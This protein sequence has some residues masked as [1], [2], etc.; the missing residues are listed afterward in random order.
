MY[1]AH[2]LSLFACSLTHVPDERT[3]QDAWFT[4]SAPTLSLGG[5]VCLRV[6]ASAAAEPAAL[7]PLTP[8]GLASSSAP[9]KDAPKEDSS[10]YRVFPY[11]HP[12]LIPFEPAVRAL[13]P[14]VAVLVRS[15][16]VTAALG[17][18]TPTQGSLDVDSSTRIQVLDKI[19]DLGGAEKDQ[20]GAFIVSP[21][22]STPLSSH[23]I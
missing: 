20:C 4:S 6:S 23:L 19:E 5:G 9:A 16:A 15:A 12:L 13:N 1:V 11:S 21:C 3:Q 14:A 22:I 2:H 17:G 10:I 8:P 7:A 18:A